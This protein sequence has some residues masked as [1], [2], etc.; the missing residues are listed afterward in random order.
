MLIPADGIVGKV[1]DVVAQLCHLLLKLEECRLVLGKVEAQ[2][3]CHT[4]LQETA[5]VIRGH[6]TEEAVGKGLDALGY[7]C[8]GSG[9]VCC[10]FEGLILVDALFDEDALE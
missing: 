10:F 9:F 7:M 4:Q 2:D 5:Q 6:R 1:G 8:Q 3:A